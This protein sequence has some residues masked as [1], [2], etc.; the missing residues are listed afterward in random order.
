MASEAVSGTPDIKTHNLIDSF[1]SLYPTRRMETVPRLKIHGLSRMTG[2]CHQHSSSE[3]PVDGENTELSVEH[4]SFYPGS[5]L[6]AASDIS[7][8]MLISTDMLK[9]EIVRGV[10]RSVQ[11]YSLPE[12]TTHADVVAAVRGGLVLD[13]HLRH[14][15]K[16]ATISFLNE[17]DAKA[18]YGHFRRHDLY[19]KN[20]RVGAT[21]NL[22]SAVSS[23]H[24]GRD[25]M[26]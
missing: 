19:I 11:L 9:H 24:L 4:S 3:S 2:R 13:I 7:Q 23:L 21:L 6:E 26:E 25:Q 12:D 14:R 20:K 10:L 8:D 16:T 17:S 5:R 18:F 1:G 22:M 15:D